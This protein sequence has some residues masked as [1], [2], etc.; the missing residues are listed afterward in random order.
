MAR[1]QHILYTSPSNLIRSPSLPN[2]VQ[3][4]PTL[5]PHLALLFLTSHPASS[6]AQHSQLFSLLPTLPCT[7]T[8]S[9][10]SSPPHPALHPHTLA[11]SPVSSHPRPA[12]SP[13]SSPP[14]PA[15]PPQPCA[16]L[17]PLS[18]PGDASLRRAAP[19]PPASCPPRSASSLPPLLSSFVP[20]LISCKRNNSVKF[21]GPICRSHHG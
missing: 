7:L 8:P 19:P 9:P 16:S 13:V 14:R 6:V 2:H 4:R 18:P 17:R 1:E 3:G 11:P 12:P 21:L 10:I 15:P 5:S 20:P